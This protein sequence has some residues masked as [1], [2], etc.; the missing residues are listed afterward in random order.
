[1][2]HPKILR[3]A[4]LAVASSVLFAACAGT[5]ATPAPTAAPATAAPSASQE[6]SASASPAASKDPNRQGIIDPA[7]LPATVPFTYNSNHV[8]V[9]VALGSGEKLPMMLDTGAP[10]EIS[11][12]IAQAGGWP[13]VMQM[14]VVGGGNATST[15]DVV[16]VDSLSVGDVKIEQVGAIK[17][18]VGPE[19][20]LSCVTEHGLF[21]ANA[22][23]DAVWQIDYEAG[24]I[25][26]A[27]SVDGLDHIAGAQ[28]VPFQPAPGLAPNPV[29]A[30]EM[31]SGALPFLIDTGSDLGIVAAPA[32]LAKVGITPADGGPRVNARIAGNEGTFEV[33][34]DF[35][36][37]PMKVGDLEIVYPVGAGD[38]VAGYGNIGN[39]FLSQFVVTFDW[40]T[41]TI[42]LDPIAADGSVNPVPVAG[43]SLTWDG[44][45]I[46][47]TSLAQG[48]PAAKDGLQVGDKVVEADGKK[49]STRDDFC[50][51]NAGTP[52]TKITTDKG[53][54]FDI[55]PVEGFYAKP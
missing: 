12:E 14:P 21:G 32:D 8:V 30:I 36:T 27:P 39:A 33:A 38:I 7:T 4:S 48:S 11:D 6:A 23:A 44:K 2:H 16:G 13:V 50:A 54:T 15:R 5:A 45:S 55:G 3:I 1:M 46:L 49:V 24:T 26:V 28:A 31:G 53:K 35:V 29:I 18:W 37:T 51:I 9:D 42:Y 25:T 41:N 19:N 47:V 22:M 43:A 34:L 20:P 17:G 52:P 40:S 10:L